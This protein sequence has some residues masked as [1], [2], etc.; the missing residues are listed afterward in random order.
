MRHNCPVAYGSNLL[1]LIAQE[2]AADL[3][4]ARSLVRVTLR[5]LMALGLSACVGWERERG[6]KA[7][8]LR[9]HML[10]SLGAALFVVAVGQA[11]GAE[12]SRV[13][14]GVAAGIGFIGGGVILKLP[15]ERRIKGLTTAASVWLCAA[16]GVAAGSGTLGAA[17]IGLLLCLLVL[18]FLQRFEKPQ[19]EKAQRE[20][21]RR[22]T[23]R[24]AADNLAVAEHAEDD[25]ETE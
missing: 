13:A 15:S 20:R 6:G 25:E 14:Q 1:N 9:T 24:R 12:L 16:I 10:V 8:G 18:G 3:P 2:L 4:D 21:E 7:A 19:H 5:L 17:V 22:K 11:G 23:E